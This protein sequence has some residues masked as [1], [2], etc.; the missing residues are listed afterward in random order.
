MFASIYLH[1]I[2]L[3]RFL[4][5]KSHAPCH[6]A[7]SASRQPGAI[8]GLGYY[9]VVSLITSGMS[10]LHN[11]SLLTMPMY[12]LVLAVIMALVSH[13]LAS[14]ERRYEPFSGT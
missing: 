9:L 1:K 3:D 7:E 12:F 6:A 14:H 13:R 2:Q 5:G 4:P 8:F 10:Y 11:G